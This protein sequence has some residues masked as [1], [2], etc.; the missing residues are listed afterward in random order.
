[1]ET[2]AGIRVT[3][4]HGHKIQLLAFP[5]LS[6]EENTLGWHIKHKLANLMLPMTTLSGEADMSPTNILKTAASC[7]RVMVLTAKDAGRLPGSLVRNTK[8][9]FGPDAGE[10]TVRVTTLEVQPARERTGFERLDERTTE[11]LA[12]HIVQ[13]MAAY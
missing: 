5:A 9:E 4:K 7:D 11:A 2:I 6:R 12:E 13:E 3:N 8:A 1:M 10:K